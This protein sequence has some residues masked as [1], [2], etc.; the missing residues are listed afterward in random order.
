MLLRL[1][2]K[3]ILKWRLTCQYIL[4]NVFKEVEKSV[5]L[6]GRTYPKKNILIMEP[7]L[8][9]YGKDIF[10]QICLFHERSFVAKS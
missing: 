10:K 4:Q 8:A 1:I 5:P 3:I 7:D 9:V 6:C 2:T